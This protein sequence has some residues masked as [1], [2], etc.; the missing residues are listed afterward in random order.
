[1]KRTLIAGFSQIILI[2]SLACFSCETQK[3]PASLLSLFFFFVCACQQRSWSQAFQAYVETGYKNRDMSRRHA[4]FCE[5][6]LGAID[7]KVLELFRN[8]SEHEFYRLKALITLE[9]VKASIVGLWTGWVL[10]TLIFCKWVFWWACGLFSAMIE[11]THHLHHV[12]GL[13][14]WCNFSRIDFRVFMHAY[15]IIVKYDIKSKY[16]EEYLTVELS[17]KWKTFSEEILF[18]VELIASSFL[19]LTPSKRDLTLFWRRSCLIIF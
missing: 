8:G 18:R 6:S 5:E 4:L 14:Q 10:L 15:S 16:P 13:W 3:M 19:I 12:F 1:M 9:Q 7:A 2:I 17:R 11:M